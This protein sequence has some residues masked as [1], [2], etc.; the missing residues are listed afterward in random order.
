VAPRWTVFDGSNPYM[1]FNGSG[2]LQERYLEDPNGLSQFYGQVS[3]SGT[4]EWYL[5]D[6]LGSVRQV[7]SPSGSVL[8][9]ITYDLYGNLVTQTNSSY[10]PRFGYAG[11]SLDPLT[12]DYQFGARYYSPEDGRWKSQDP[13]GFAAGDTDLYGYVFNDPT[14]LVDPSGLGAEDGSKPYMKNIDVLPT[15][16]PKKNHWEFKDQEGTVFSVNL[17]DIGGGVPST[18][19]GMIEPRSLDKANWPKG[20]LGWAG[21][22]PF[23][24]CTLAWG[25]NAWVFFTNEKGGVTQI[26]WYNFQVTGDNGKGRGFNCAFA[27]AQQD[28]IQRD[29]TRLVNANMNNPDEA[30]KA[31]KQYL[32]K[33]KDI[34]QTKDNTQI[35]NLPDGI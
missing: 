21:G 7:V 12:G 23:G 33:S 24:E 19:R 25:V 20:T 10:Q 29:L 5:T 16:D 15:T 3:A 22:G 8:D 13:L 31:I 2:Q 35:W 1:D 4:T 32:K 27:R 30:H 11:G 9:A 28:K 34:D 6:L 14:N 26:I 18:L 17:V